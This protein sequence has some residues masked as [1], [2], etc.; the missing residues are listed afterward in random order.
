MFWNVLTMSGEPLHAQSPGLC[1]PKTHRLLLNKWTSMGVSEGI[2]P[3][4]IKVRVVSF[5]WMAP[6]RKA[7][8]AVQWEKNKVSGWKVGR[9]AEVGWK[10]ENRKEQRELSGSTVP[11]PSC[12]KGHLL[13]QREDAGTSL[14]GPGWPEGWAMWVL[15]LS[16]VKLSLHLWGFGVPAKGSALH[17]SSTPVYH[18]LYFLRR[19]WTNEWMGSNGRR[20]GELT[21]HLRHMVSVIH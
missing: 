3:R 18:S 2:Q 1:L 7:N 12:R 16:S 5:C 9:K 14:G 15:F 4:G 10:V 20:Q 17:L 8:E 21:S 19:K 11:P 6:G 13:Q